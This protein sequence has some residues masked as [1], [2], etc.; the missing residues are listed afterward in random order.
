MQRCEEHQRGPEGKPAVQVLALLAEAKAEADD[1]EQ[2][3][4]RLRREHSRQDGRRLVRF[5]RGELRER[6]G[7]RMKGRPD[8]QQHHARGEAGIAEHARP[9]LAPTARE[10]RGCD[11]DP[12]EEPSGDAS[13]ALGAVDGLSA[14]HGRDRKREIGESRA[15]EPGAEEEIEPPTL[16]SEPDAG[17]QRHDAGREGDRRLEDEAQLREHPVGVEVPVRQ[18]EGER[19]AEQAEQEDLA[20]EECLEDVSAVLLHVQSCRQSALRR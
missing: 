1:R 8:Q 19:G 9:P 7:E 12:G 14:D 3:Q 6:A 2:I 4:Q 13:P 5:V 15:E 16:D 10:R 20:P 17:E 18:E 11:Q